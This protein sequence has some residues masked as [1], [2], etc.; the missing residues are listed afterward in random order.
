[1][2]LVAT[3]PTAEHPSSRAISLLLP[4]LFFGFLLSYG[5]RVVFGLVLKP[6]EASLHLSDSE[7]GLLSGFAFAVTYA[8]ASPLAGYLV[9]RISRKTIFL[10]A[11]AFWSA[12]SFSCGL[13]TTKVAMALGRGAVGVGEALM[14]PLAV[15]II[16]DTVALARRARAM[17]FFFTG[18][19]VGS[20]GVLL[21]GGLLLRHLGRSPVR[22]P[23]LGSVQ[24]WQTLFLLLAVP[25]LLLCAAVLFS[26]K[27]P[28]RPLRGVDQSLSPAQSGSVMVFLRSHRVLTAALFA[29]YPLLQMPG[30]AVA[31][32]AF[33]YF[34][35]VYG[36]PLEQAAVAFSFT[37]GITSIL[38]C[39]L[40]GRL[41]LVLRRRGY[42]DAS[43]RACLLGGLLF[44]IFA[45]LG[46]LAPGPASA[47]AFFSAAFFFSYVPTVGAYSAISEIT[48]SPIRA[49]VSGLNALTSGVLA[50]SLGPY[51]VGVFSDYLFPANRFGIRWALLATLTVSILC[52][53]ALVYAG[54]AAL[55][56][57]VGELQTTRAAAL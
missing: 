43:L 21:F 26:M 5:D 52:G 16:G 14:V 31:A 49:S 55:R 30:I 36:M 15:S 3:D 53:A 48:P 17:S 9:D 11:V 28:P 42:S 34:D 7:A 2:A 20:L 50:T 35:R 47:L 22:L 57:R 10:F 37:A 41:V 40:S 25:G 23:I 18:G 45:V 39:V 46:L 44:G 6:I 33:I 12:A 29:G 27:D 19:P 38:G 13:A 51:L 8:L 1:M 4:L 24:P 32:W 54:L 56:S